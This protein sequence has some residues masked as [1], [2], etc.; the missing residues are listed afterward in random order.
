MQITRRIKNEIRDATGEDAARTECLCIDQHAAEASIFATLLY[1]QRWSYR[2]GDLV[3]I[4]SQV[5]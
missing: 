1:T 2:S 4:Q 3:F 5:A